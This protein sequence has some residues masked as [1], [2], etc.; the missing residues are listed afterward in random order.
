VNKAEMLQAIVKRTDLSPR[1]VKAVV[2]AIFNPGDGV[3]AKA[4][5]KGDKVVISGFGAFEQRKR[6]AR[7]ARNPQTG[8]AVKVKARRVPAFRAGAS[9]KETVR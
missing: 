5:K 4:M 2:D 1:D 3:L 7:V 6:G 9:L 8:A